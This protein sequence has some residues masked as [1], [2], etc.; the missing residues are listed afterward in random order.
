MGGRDHPEGFSVH[1][2]PTRDDHRPTPTSPPR[3]RFRWF[4]GLALLATVLGVSGVVVCAQDP[5]TNTATRP[6]PREGAWMQMHEDF[7]KRAS[8]GDVDLLFLGDSIT[9]GWA[10]DS[11][12]GPRAVW[13]RYYAPRHAANFGIGG[14]RTQHVLWRLEHGEL[15]GIKPRVVVLMIGTN[16]V[17]ANTPAEIADGVTAVVK[18]LRA[19]LPSTKVLL[20]GV[21]PRGKTPDAVRERLK[22]VNE[23]IARLDDGG[24]TVE[25]LDIGPRFLNPDG[26]ISQEIMPDF[27]HLSRKGYHI[28]ADAM[29]P[30]LWTLM[31]GE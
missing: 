9:R 31:E 23:R 30:T 16:N 10:N 24:K 6:E 28:W 15:D 12:Q 3:R 22:A 11:D 18:T 26:T 17:H 4:L 20:L 14:D 13:E 1:T 29:E 5:D 25:Y 7:L 21:F 19:K 27:L 8:G 2:E